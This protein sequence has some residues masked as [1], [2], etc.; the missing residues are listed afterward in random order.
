[1]TREHE[2]TGQALSAAG[3]V[4]DA[5]PKTGDEPQKWLERMLVN[6]YLTARKHFGNPKNPMHMVSIAMDGSRVGNKEMLLLAIM[7]LN[8]GLNCWGPPQVRD[9][10]DA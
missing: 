10:H 9:F 3:A 2:S 8:T 1:M 4:F 6:Y 7:G 5:K